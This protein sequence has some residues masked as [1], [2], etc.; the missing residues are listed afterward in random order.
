MKEIIHDLLRWRQAGKAIALATIV[1]TRGSALRPAGT[2]M[3]ITTD[4]EV[5]GSVSS[6]C[7]DG[8]VVAE[9]EWVLNGKAALR[10]PHFGI[11]RRTGV[12]CGAF[13]RRHP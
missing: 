10:R 6:G 12:E 8:D 1:E 3:A 2:R 5:A 11:Q 7:V 4:G 13:V 9:M